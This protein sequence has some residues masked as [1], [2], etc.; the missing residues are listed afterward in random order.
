MRLTDEE[1]EHRSQPPLRHRRRA[2]KAAPDLDVVEVTDEFEGLAPEDKVYRTAEGYLVKVKCVR[3]PSGHGAEDIHVT[4]SIVGRDGKALRRED[5]ELCIHRE[6][7][8]HTHKADAFHEPEIALEI[9]RR[10]AVRA[11][12]NAERH[13]Q[14]LNRTAHVVTRDQLAARKAEEAANADG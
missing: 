8:S 3:G 1:R 6:G 4:P 2:P 5:G 11:G 10:L 12:V 9:S 14:M 13:Y 7:V